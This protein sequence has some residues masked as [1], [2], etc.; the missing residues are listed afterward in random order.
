MWNINKAF[1]D[2]QMAQGKT[3]LF[4]GNP[5]SSSA[6]Y[7]TKLEFSHLSENGYVIVR[8]GGFYRAIKK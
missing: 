4:T 1:L 3:F 7:F 6:G 8:E 2:Q 5:A